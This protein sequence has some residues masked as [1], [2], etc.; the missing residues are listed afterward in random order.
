V[1][2][3]IDRLGGRAPNLV[4]DHSG[5]DDCAGSIAGLVSLKSASLAFATCGSRDARGLDLVVTVGP[6]AL[7]FSWRG[8]AD[9]GAAGPSRAPLS[10]TRGPLAKIG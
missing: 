4:F 10:V 9:W 2:I 1:Q 8:R 6:N 7:L 3:V 5:T